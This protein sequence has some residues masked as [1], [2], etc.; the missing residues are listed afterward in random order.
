MKSDA[1]C[2][3]QVSA[4][5]NGPAQHCLMPSNVV[6]YTELD[7]ECDQQL[8]A[9]DCTWPHPPSS[10]G[11]VNDRPMTCSPMVD[12]PWPYFLSPDFD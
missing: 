2:Y 5:A 9:V 6:L 1:H 11:A 7:A 3:R 12:M 8:K 4:D 10:P